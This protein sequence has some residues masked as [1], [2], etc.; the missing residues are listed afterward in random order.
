MSSF[1]D[2]SLGYLNHVTG[3]LLK[4]E[5]MEAIKRKGI[6][7]TP[8]QWALLNRLNEQQGL[9][10]KELARISFKDTA[11]ITRIIDKLE[12]KGLVERQASPGDR[13]VWKI[14]NTDQGRKVRD[15]I[16]PLAIETLEKATKGIDAKEVELFNAV[17]KR[18]IKNLDR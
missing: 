7:I 5:L 8:E 10:Q 4:R 18:I 2:Q 16:E 13:R 1:L 14:Y 3:L 9:T 17:A 6:D 12:A 15:L 11:N